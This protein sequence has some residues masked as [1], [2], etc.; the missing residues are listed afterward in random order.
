MSEAKVAEQ[1]LLLLGACHQFLHL[2]S[3]VGCAQGDE[4][5]GIEGGIEGFGIEV[6]LSFRLLPSVSQH[7]VEEIGHHA[8]GVYCDHMLFGMDEEGSDLHERLDVFECVFDVGLVSVC[9][10]DF[11]GRQE[12][13]FVGTGLRMVG[14]KHR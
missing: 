13:G 11:T 1:L 14:N 4:F 2:L 10:D 9:P 12:I 3:S 6:V 8:E 7:L 5:T